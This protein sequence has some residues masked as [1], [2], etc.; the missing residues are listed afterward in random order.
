MAETIKQILIRRDAI[1]PEKADQLII[2]AQNAFYDY[3]D[4]NDQEAAY[5]VCMEYFSLEPD[6]LSELM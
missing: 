5:N 3:L 6:Y 4:N 2:E 1:P